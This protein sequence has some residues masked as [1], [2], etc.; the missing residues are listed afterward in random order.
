[1]R[2]LQHEV[3]RFRPVA[4]ALHSGMGDAS[5]AVEGRPQSCETFRICGKTGW[6]D[7]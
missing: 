5:N 3:L 1:M 6:T 2:A 7:R 4:A